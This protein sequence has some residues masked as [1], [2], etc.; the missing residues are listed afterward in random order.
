MLNQKL[1]NIRDED[2][3]ITKSQNSLIVLIFQKLNE[4]VS[5]KYYSDELKYKK[6]SNDMRKN[7]EEIKNDIKELK[8]LKGI[9]EKL[10]L[11]VDKIKKKAKF[12]IALFPF[13]LLEK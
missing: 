4:D 7:I 8:E 10:A 5:Q 6:E 12:K 2:D 13:S 1:N 3:E 9:I 11:S